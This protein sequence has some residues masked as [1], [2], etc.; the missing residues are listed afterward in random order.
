[1]KTILILALLSCVA[2]TIY[3]QG[4]EPTEGPEPGPTGEPDDILFLQDEVEKD[5]DRICHDL[6]DQLKDICENELL[7]NLDKV[8]ED[9]QKHTPYELCQ[10]YKNC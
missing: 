6:P 4:P 5:L 1:M 9:L 7:P 3:A 10:Q 2:L 8:Y